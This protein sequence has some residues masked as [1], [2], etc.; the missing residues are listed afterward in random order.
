MIEFFGIEGEESSISLEM[1]A[2]FRKGE[3][4]L[5]APPFNMCKMGDI[6]NM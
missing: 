6:P 3:I 4:A 2:N 1:R 5:H